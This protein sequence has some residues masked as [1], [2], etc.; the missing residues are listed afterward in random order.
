MAAG[1]TSRTH[2]CILWPLCMRTHWNLIA[3]K[4][5][6]VLGGGHSMGY[7]LFTTCVYFRFFFPFE[8]GTAWVIYRVDACDSSACF[9]YVC[10]FSF[11]FSFWG[12]GQHGLFTG[13]TL[14][15]AVPVFTSAM[16]GI[17]VGQVCMKHYFY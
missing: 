7:S 13:W 1:H 4:F 5:C 12:E 11:F 2:E 14:L 17:F 6:F 9:Y 8:G 10:V 16:G 3:G 15:T